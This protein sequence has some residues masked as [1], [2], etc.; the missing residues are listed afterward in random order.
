MEKKTWKKN[1]EIPPSRKSCR[2]NESEVI[3]FVFLV[4]L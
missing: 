2:L 1:T 3:L 4:F